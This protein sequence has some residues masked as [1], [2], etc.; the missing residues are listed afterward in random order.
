ML[1]NKR[2]W[3]SACG[4]LRAG[5]EVVVTVEKSYTLA[6]MFSELQKEIAH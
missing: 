3:G 6:M 2:C 1:L 4:L 5:L